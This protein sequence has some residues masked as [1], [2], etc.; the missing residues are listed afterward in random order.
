MRLI[1]LTYALLAASQLLGCG[2]S[3][4]ENEPTKVGRISQV[5]SANPDFLSASG[6]LFP[7]SAYYS[8]CVRRV[9]VLRASIDEGMRGYPTVT[10]I[11]GDM[12]KLRIG[13]GKFGLWPNATFIDV[14]AVS[15]PRR[16]QLVREKDNSYVLL[17]GF[18]G[19][20]HNLVSI[21][22]D[23]GD[24]K[25]QADAIRFANSVV[26]CHLYPAGTKT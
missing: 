11:T 3:P 26:A 24:P 12:G 18:E 22:F 7:L 25:A 4:R 10:E 19:A 14:P 5:R 23:D 13:V 17:S 8:V 15:P 21:D 1:F 2:Q 6:E 9:G 16:I 20:G